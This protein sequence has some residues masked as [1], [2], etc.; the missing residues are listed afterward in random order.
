[1]RISIYL[2]FV[3]LFFASCGPIKTT[4]DQSE[5]TR[6]NVL[7]LVADDVSF[8]SF[9][10]AGGVAP[11]VTPNID[12][13]AS[14]GISFQKAFSTV[15]VCQPS[16]QSMLTG[17]IPNHYGS[18]G[19]FPVKSG[20]P[21]LPAILR[22]SGYMTGIIHKEHHLEPEEE[23]NWNYNNE[24][25]GLTQ[26]DGMVG[27]TPNLIAGGLKKMILDA[28]D[29]DKPFFMVVGS[30]DAHR[31]FH[32][33]PP[34]KNIEFWGWGEVDI[35]YPDPSRIYSPDEITVTPSLPD[36]PGIREDLAKYASSVRRLDDSV[37]ECLK[38][39]D[40]TGAASNTIVIF[41]SDNGMPLPFGKFDTYLG[42]NHSPLLIRWPEKIKK[43]ARNENNLISLMDVTPTILE[44]AGLPIPSPMDGRSLVP[45]LNG[46]TPELWRESIVFIRNQD[47]NYGDALKTVL[48]R[49]PDFTKQLEAVGWKPSPE[50]KVE[51]TYVREKEIRSFYDGR[52]GYIYYDCYREDG[53]EIGPI[54][55]IVP[56]NGRAVKILKEAGK[57]DKKVKARY[58]SF[59]LRAP[60][61]LYDWSVDP[62]ST[63]NLA[64]DP[65]YAEILSEARKGL[66]AY[67]ESAKDPIIDDF[68]KFIK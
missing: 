7:I 28:E 32:G 11:D 34:N 51:G 16:R 47:I 1:M 36:V 58:E 66:L 21:N 49:I 62:G 9:G 60:E 2:A 20:T 30:A 5:S 52:Y 42:S 43:G 63:N 38:V 61:E 4:S 13:L 26:P 46:K 56:Y 67:M 39:L 31:P 19:F 54:G 17:L 65:K 35:S 12:R 55:T 37:G 33:D 48:K 15:A 6:P 14:E 25:L 45:F 3:I 27:R 18:Q 64:T 23:F 59:L 68:K 50:H 24:R 57:T 22:E 8:D 40:E 44:I 29:G 41:V 53:L 10:F